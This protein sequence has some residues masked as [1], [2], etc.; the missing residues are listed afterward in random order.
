MSNLSSSSSMPYTESSKR[1]ELFDESGRILLLRRV[2]DGVRLEEDGEG[3]DMPGRLPPPR[4]LSGG[5][6]KGKGKGKVAESFDRG[7]HIQEGEIMG[8]ISFRFDTEETLGS[9]DAEVIYWYVCRL[10]LY[11]K[12]RSLSETEIQL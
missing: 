6:V 11:W 2:P 8:Y 9:R 5:N 4:G 3:V 7:I 10:W 12:I 1:E